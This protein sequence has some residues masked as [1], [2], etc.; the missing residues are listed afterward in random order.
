MTKT[1]NEI[2]EMHCH[3]RISPA[4]YF[5]ALKE[6]VSR[7][8]L[9]KSVKRFRET[10]SCLLNARLPQKGLKEPKKF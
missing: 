4:K 3:K 7:S 1:V 9:Y 10:G 5:K 6:I 2:V 8:G